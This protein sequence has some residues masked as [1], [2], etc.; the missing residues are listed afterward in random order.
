MEAKDAPANTGDAG[1]PPAAGADLGARLPRAVAARE[2]RKRWAREGKA[3]QAQAE[4]G[5]VQ[6]RARAAREGELRR[7]EAERTEQA[8]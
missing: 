4:E 5:E 7:R 1:A 3:A 2:G 6:A 8:R